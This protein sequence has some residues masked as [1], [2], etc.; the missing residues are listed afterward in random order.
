VSWLPV[1]LAESM[2]RAYEKD[3]VAESALARPCCRLV[4]SN[5]RGENICLLSLTITVDIL[6]LTFWVDRLMLRRP[7]LERMEFRVNT[8]LNRL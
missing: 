3:G 5:A 7:Q 2:S 8:D 6:K 4:G 1:S